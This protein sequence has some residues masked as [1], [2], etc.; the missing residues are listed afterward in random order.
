MSDGEDLFAIAARELRTV[1]RTPAVVALSVVFGLTVVAVAAAGTGSRGGYVP[2]VLDLVPFVEALVP[3]LAFA[4]CYRA[5][6]TDRRTGELDV[7]RT[8]DVSRLSYV[9]GVYLG[10][11]LA[12]VVV[13]FG[14]LLVSAATVPVLSPE[15]S[16]FL[17]LNAA[18]DSPVA[19][20]RFA[21]LAVIFAL[22]TAAVALAVSAAARTARQ[23]IALAVGLVVA[24]VV[25]IDAAAVAGLAS[26][27]FG[28]DAVPLVLALSPNGA[29]RS[30]VF[31][32]AVETGSH[33]SP[34]VSLL[35]LAGWLSGALVLAV[36]TAW[37]PVD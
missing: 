31:G 30:L 1:V 7:L 27:T 12:L 3:L 6:L 2:L 29:F 5:V 13:V 22:A 35:G 28:I 24:F 23:A 19:F 25:G 8:F 37:K 33:T 18:A 9:G 10:R 14:S 34:L 20:V 36:L 26:G 15:K 32:V 16:A 4:L 11:S 21:V 17:A